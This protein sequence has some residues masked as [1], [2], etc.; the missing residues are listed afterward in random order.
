MNK[1]TSF[2][3][4][5]LIFGMAHGEL[6]SLIYLISHLSSKNIIIICPLTF[7]VHN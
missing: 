5:R 4:H 3:R 2:S 6:I 1:F 7:G